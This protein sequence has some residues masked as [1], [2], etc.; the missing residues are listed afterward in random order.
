MAV[1]ICLGCHTD[2]EQRYAVAAILD[3]TQRRRMEQELRQT[4]QAVERAYQRFQEDRPTAARVQLSFLPS[5]VLQVQGVLVAWRYLPC[6]ELGGDGLNVFPV[7]SS[8]LGLYLFDVSGHGVAAALLSISLNRQ[9]LPQTL[10]QADAPAELAARLNHWLLADAVNDQF[11]T[12]VYGILDVRSLVFRYVSAGHPDILRVSATGEAHFEPGQSIL[13][14]IR[15]TAVFTEQ[16]V[17]LHPGDTLVLCSDGILESQDAQK[18]LFGRDR[19]CRC[20]V[21]VLGKG[22]DACVDAVVKSA[23]AWAG[24]AKHDDL[25]IIALTVTS[26]SQ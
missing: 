17:Q 2:G 4:R 21:D 14:D 20:V 22:L 23:E 25:S 18:R 3:I 19:L 11:F 5:R 6:A 9:L 12:L 7:G 10:E 8:H 15:R 13:G 1:G 24:G 16:T 26:P